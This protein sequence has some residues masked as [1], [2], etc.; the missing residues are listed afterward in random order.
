[1]SLI[2]HIRH[3]RAA[4]FCTRGMREWLAHHG[5]DL[6]DVV[7]NGIPIEE[8]EATGDAL[9]KRVCDE[10]RKEAES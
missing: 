5:Y 10:A 8:L 4:H 1:M 6:G 9:V 7:R 2:V 3:V